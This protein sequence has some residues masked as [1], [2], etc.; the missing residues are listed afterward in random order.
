MQYLDLSP[1]KGFGTGDD[2]FKA[3]GWLSKTHAF[4]TGS[5]PSDIIEALR[6]FVKESWKPWITA[7][8]HHCEF[9]SPAGPWTLENTGSSEIW[10]P[11]QGVIFVAPTLILHYVEA[12]HYKP[13]DELLHALMTCPPQFSDEWFALMK[14]ASYFRN[15]PGFGPN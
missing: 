4:S 8:H 12:H 13:P 5:I 10:L 11:A 1:W 9:C 15:L 6:L 3:V 7:G 2:V 14:Q